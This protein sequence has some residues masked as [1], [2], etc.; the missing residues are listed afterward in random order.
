MFEQNNR[1]NRGVY[2][3]GKKKRNPGFKIRVCKKE[4][5]KKKESMRQE[6]FI[7]LGRNKC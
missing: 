1:E 3:K 7:V 2:K 6:F 5:R 4:R